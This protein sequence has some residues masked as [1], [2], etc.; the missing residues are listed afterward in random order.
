MLSYIKIA[1]SFFILCTLSLQ[2]QIEISAVFGD[3]MV[4]Q[5]REHVSI[6]GKDNPGTKIEILSSWGA[7]AKAIANSDGFWKTTIKTKKAS[8]NPEELQIKGSTSITLC[9]ILIGEVWFCSGQSNM[10]MPLQGLRQSK[11]L[12]AEDYLLKSNN[13]YIRLLNNARSAS[14][15]PS[16]N[17]NGKWSVSDKDGAKKFSAIGYIFGTKLFE[18]LNVPIG[19]IE[20][21]WGGTR[22]ESWI[23]KQ[24]LLK[25][26]DIK[27]SDNLPKE[28]NKQKKPAFLYNAMVHPFQDF[29]VK[30]FLWYQGES[31]R[32]QP[33]PYKNYMEDLISSWRLQWKNDKLPFYFVQIAPYNYKKHKKGTSLRPNLIR[34][35]QLQTAQEIKNT[36]LVVTTD[37]GDCSDIHPSKKEIVAKRLSNWALANQY[38]FKKI[39]FK[40]AELKSYEITNSEVNLYF[41]FYKKDKFINTKNVKGFAIAGADKIF[42][43]ANVVFH[44]NGKQITLSSQNVK[45]PVAIRYGFEAC[46]ESNLKTKSGLPISVFRTDNW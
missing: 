2:S 7:K 26:N 16:F 33:K 21:A 30:G 25:Y 24:V 14:V 46:Y 35:A 31:N 9:N 39:A 19:I 8:F 36:G 45:T 6:W 28:E 5:Q 11:V 20:S 41:Q 23:P 13:K 4:L 37:A 1:L 44:K 42:Y 43:P 40:S 10:E 38:N 34:E 27:F 12:H 32:T 3:N 15:M 22:I 18:K 29:T 17:V